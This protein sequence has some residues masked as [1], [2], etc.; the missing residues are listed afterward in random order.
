[1]L[2]SIMILILVWGR[3]LRVELGRNNILLRLR[4][5][6][7]LRLKSNLLCWLVVSGLQ[8]VLVG[9]VEHNPGGDP[10]TENEDEGRGDDELVVH[11]LKSVH[12]KSTKQVASSLVPTTG[13]KHHRI[14]TPYRDTLSS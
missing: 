5:K 10:N 13:T 6:A 11:R 2:C 3:G 12:D 1:M 8:D 14:I 7:L 4:S 9:F